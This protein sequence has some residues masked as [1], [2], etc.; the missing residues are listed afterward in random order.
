[1]GFSEERFGFGFFF[2]REIFDKIYLYVYF[3]VFLGGGEIE[4]AGNSVISDDF[5]LDFKCSFN[6]IMIILK[7]RKARIFCKLFPCQICSTDKS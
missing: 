1:M 4:I 6:L 2:L 5:I 3:K 7:M